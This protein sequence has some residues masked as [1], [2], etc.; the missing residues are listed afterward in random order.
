MGWREGKAGR[1]RERD[2]DCRAK[3]L[4]LKLRT[5]NGDPVAKQE[6]GVCDVLL[7]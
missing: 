3:P 5:Q 4:F 6:S 2:R 7:T 1:E